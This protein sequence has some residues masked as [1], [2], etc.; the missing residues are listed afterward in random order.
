M[1]YVVD[2]VCG[3]CFGTIVPDGYGEWI[4]EAGFMWGWEG[5]VIYEYG[6]DGVDS[7]KGRA[8]T[9]VAIPAGKRRRK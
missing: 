4:H 5:A 2:E 8:S 6:C 1:R 3:N 9:R 7:A